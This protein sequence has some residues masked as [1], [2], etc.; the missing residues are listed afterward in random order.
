MFRNVFDRR[1]KRKKLIFFDLVNNFKKGLKNP[2]K[3]DSDGD[4]SD[5]R[6]RELDDE[7]DE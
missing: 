2:P 3:Y 6:D 5:D 4:D 1:N 7:D